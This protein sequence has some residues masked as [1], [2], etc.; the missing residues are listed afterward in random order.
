MF[1]CIFGRMAS[2]HLAVV[3]PDRMTSTMNGVP[4]LDA[5]TVSGLGYIAD[6][7]A[8]RGGGG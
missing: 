7:W 6:R 8:E 5:K 1:L 3:I 4:N 2:P